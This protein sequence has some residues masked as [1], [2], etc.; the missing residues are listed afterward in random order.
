MMNRLRIAAAGALAGAALMGASAASAND[1]TAELAAGGLVLTHSDGIEMRSEDLSISREAVKVHYIFRNTTGHDVTALVAFPM[2]GIT[3]DIDFMEAVPTE[4]PENLLGFTTTVD[5]RPVKARVEQRVFFKGQE[6]TALLRRWG[7]PLAPHTDAAVTALDR[8]PKAQQAQLLKM[9][10][11][12]PN[13]YDAGKGWEH[14]LQPLWTL[15]TTYYWEQAFPAGR[16]MVVEHRY[17]PSVGQSA[18]S[19]LGMSWLKGKELAE[20]RAKYCVD[21]AFMAAVDKAQAR[22]G[23]DALVFT[24]ARVD[25]ILSSGGNWK[26]PIGDFHLTVDK[27]RPDTLVSFCA[28]GVRKAGPTRFESRLADFRPS[29]DLHILFLDPTPQQ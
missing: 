8:L 27:G 25:Y 18:G 1:S 15:K 17:T 26:K 16:D 4:D 10:M 7:V 11:V 23:K 14:H 12:A 13:D 29:Q 9:E 5:G 2:P 28:T 22:V 3:G 24:E 6:Y 19:G 20:F 21:D